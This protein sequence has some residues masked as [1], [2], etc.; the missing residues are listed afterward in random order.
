[1]SECRRLGAFNLNLT[2]PFPF[3]S[4][5]T[6]PANREAGDAFVFRKAELQGVSGGRF[7]RGSTPAP[8]M[9]PIFSP[10]RFLC[11]EFPQFLGHLGLS[12]GRPKIDKNERVRREK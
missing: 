7:R 3:F 6:R 2:A 5:G 1:M 12:G 10:G 4:G 9:S 11:E 8:L